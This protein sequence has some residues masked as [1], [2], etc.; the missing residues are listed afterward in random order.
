MAS[1]EVVKAARSAG[2]VIPVHK[3]YTLQ[4]TGVWERIRRLFAVDPNRSTGI[5]MNPQY[6]NPPSGSNDPLAYED[7][8]TVPAGDLAENPYWKRDARRAYPQ[9]SVVNQAD[10][11]GLLSVGSKATPK[12]DVPLVGD[13]GAKQL[14]QVKQEGEERGL[15]QL[16][17]KDKKMMAGVLGPGGMP[18]LPSG[19]SPAIGVKQ[20]QQTA[21]NAYPEEYV[22]P[23]Y[24]HQWFD[25][26]SAGTHVEHLNRGPY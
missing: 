20:Y 11:V 25:L 8:V 22:P 18:P 26:T 16:F 15:S 4:S 14:V 17:E 9:L 24:H 21:E 2:G 5:P 6:R 13:A 23:E 1:K 12:D 10:V 3:K 19:L 7:P